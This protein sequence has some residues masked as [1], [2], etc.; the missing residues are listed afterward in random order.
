MT[1][2][3]R[4][5]GQLL[6]EAEAAMGVRLGEQRAAWGLALRLDRWRDHTGAAEP[7]N[8]FS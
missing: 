1:E 8:Q 4:G 3:G 5:D 7:P 2:S 6:S